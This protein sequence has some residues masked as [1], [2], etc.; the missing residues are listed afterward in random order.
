[1]LKIWYGTPRP[2]INVAFSQ[3]MN[4]YPEESLAR[5]YILV[6][7]SYLQENKSIRG[8]MNHKRKEKKWK[9]QKRERERKDKKNKKL[10]VF[11]LFF[12]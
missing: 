11:F 7:S 5:L 6:M 10:M 8:L 9:Q 3:I 12:I 2:S 4:Y 1:M